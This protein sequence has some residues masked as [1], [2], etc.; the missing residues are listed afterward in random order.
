[1]SFGVSF[2]RTSRK[3]GSS[4]TLA[5]AAGLV[6]IAAAA[7]GLAWDGGGGRAN[8]GPVLIGATGTVLPS[9]ADLVQRVAPAVVSLSDRRGVG[10]GFLI[11]STGYVVTNSHVVGDSTEMELRVSD[12]TKFKAR[13]VGRDEATD[14]ALMKVDAPR[15]FP[16]VKLADDGKVRVGDWVLAVGNPFGLGG[17]VT[18]GIVSARGR[19]EVGKGQYTDYFQLDAAINPGNSGGPTFDMSGRV[20]G[21][22]TLGGSGIGFAIPASTIQ[23][24]VGDLKATGT[25]SRGYLGVQIGS[26]SDD[27]ARSLG[28]ASSDGA[29]VTEVINGSPAQSAGIKRGD[30][31]LKINGQPVKDSR[32]LSRRITALQAGEKATFTIW[33]DNKQLTITVT[34]AKRAQLA[35]VDFDPGLTSLGLGLQT[36]TSEVRSVLNLSEDSSGVLIIDVSPGSDAAENGLK[37]GDRIIQVGSDNVTSLGDINLAVE[38]AKALKRPSVLLFVMTKRG[39]IAHVSVKLNKS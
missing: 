12:G 28:L 4:A 38:Q 33:R 25:V 29:I 8:A 37:A 5:G 26:L 13:L 22:N 31:I 39:A 27:D 9:L 6:I 32:E 36:I 7:G 19:D 15:A 34:V 18:A 1:M 24:V 21:M 23:R 11:D 17:T 30:V 3:S 14:I 16:S 20:I 35:S 2:R 10:S